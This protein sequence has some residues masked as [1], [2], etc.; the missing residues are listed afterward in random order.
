M[1]PIIEKAR[2]I[3]D[4]IRYIKKFEGATTVIYLDDEIIN[5]SLLPSHI[6][7]IRLIHDAGLKVIIVPGARKRI[8]EI[9][10]QSKIDWKI[11]NGCRI[12][13]PQAIPLI[14]MA[15]FDVSNTIMTALAGENI[16]AVIGN[17]VKARGKGVLDG[18]DYADSGEIESFRI[19]AI[20]N[21]LNDG[22]I[23]ILPCI[24]WTATGKPYNISS[25]QLANEIAIS[26][27]ADKLFYILPDTQFNPE[28]YNIPANINLS[29]EFNMPGINLDELHEFIES[30]KINSTE[31]EE[32]DKNT[33]P[34]KQKMINLMSLAEQA[35]QKGVSR[36]HIL[37]GNIDG[38]I[39]CEIFSGIGS[40]TMIYNNDY[41]GFRP[42]KLKDISAVLSL[43]DPF[44][45]QGMLLPRT[46]QQLAEAIDDFMVYEVD[47]GIHACAALHLYDNG[48]QAEIACV[49]VNESYSKLGIGNKLIHYL[50][51]KAKEQKIP[52]VFV[53]TT[54][55]ADW[56]EKLGFKPDNVSSLPEKRKAKWTPERNSKVLRI[57]F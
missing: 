25:L 44:V 5:S 42:M 13:G 39:P 11:H 19:E 20:T 49:A 32:T 4:V 56:F 21:C 53:L 51:N 14:K 15:A 40:G 36:V 18:I 33:L 27:R 8:N 29:P 28:E 43:M 1:N 23:P 17:W 3:R 47:G 52:T 7:D 35:C 57:K 31:I 55:T 50:L 30:N 48:Q 6:R 46:K 2:N 9:L 24:G 22:L 37:N 26:L 54:Q 10:S 12:T 38:I 45:S 16:S 41:G 34:K